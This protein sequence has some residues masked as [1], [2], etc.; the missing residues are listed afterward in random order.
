MT[1][2][3][4]S[5]SAYER[6]NPPKKKARPPAFTE[7]IAEEILDRISTGESLR[8]ICRSEHIPHESTVRKWVRDDEWGDFTARFN[9]ARDLGMDAVA[10]ELLEIA[11]DGRNDWMER[12]GESG[13]GWAVNGEHI[14]RSRLRVDTRK[15]LLAKIAPK[16]Y[17][18]KLEVTNKTELQDAS[19][20]ELAQAIQRRMAALKDQGIDVS[21]LI[22]QDDNGGA[23]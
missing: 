4:A 23:E 20:E 19:D 12:S 1:A 6:N 18:E 9:R 16:R 8:S 3:K 10:D 17:G 21:R 7:E 5:K 15:F 13:S 11:D 2:K 14:Q 22:P